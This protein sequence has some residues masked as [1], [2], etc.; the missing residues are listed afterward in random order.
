MLLQVAASN[1][2]GC[3]INVSTIGKC[4]ED[5]INQSFTDCTAPV[6]GSGLNVSAWLTFGLLGYWFPGRTVCYSPSRGR[7]GLRLSVFVQ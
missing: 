4:I 5:L 3:A 7:G 1:R 2:F 6:N